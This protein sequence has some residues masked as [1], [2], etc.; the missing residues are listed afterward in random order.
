VYLNFSAFVVR[1]NQ[2]RVDGLAYTAPHSPHVAANVTK[3]NDGHSKGSSSSSSSSSAVVEDT[4][5]DTK[6][7]VT[8]EDGAESGVFYALGS[9]GDVTEVV[10]ASAVKKQVG[11]TKRKASVSK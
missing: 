6:K 1:Q 8:V 3:K 4:K 11:G 7:S 9:T 2:N 10:R 5:P